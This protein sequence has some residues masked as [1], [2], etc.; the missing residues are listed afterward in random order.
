VRSRTLGSTGLR[1]SEVGLGG[2]TFGSSRFGVDE[3]AGIEIISRALDLGITLFDTAR[4]YGDGR[5][6]EIVGK[7]LAGHRHEVVIVSKAGQRLLEGVDAPGLGRRD[8]IRA[9]DASLRS[10]RTDYVDVYMFH[11]PDPVTPLEQSVR[12]MEELIRAG[13][14]RYYGACNYPAWQLARMVGIADRFSME[15]V[16]VTQVQYNLIDRRVETE[17]VPCCLELE[18]GLIA[19]TPLA[20]GFLTGKYRRDTPAPSGSRLDRAPTFPAFQGLTTESH[21]AM[22]E[23]FESFARERGHAVHELAFAWLLARPGVSTV[24]PGAT[25]VQQV[26]DNVR[27]ADWRLNPDEADAVAALAGASDELRNL[28]WSKPAR[29]QS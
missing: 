9:V 4:I 28:A 21:F 16:R 27:A 19:Y 24:I 25:S 3:K 13:K 2:N 7:G 8:L 22:L 1:I 26:E 29:L 10:L 12:A 20:R 18:L 5:S 15:P 6:E 17:V 23:R 14:I 11:V